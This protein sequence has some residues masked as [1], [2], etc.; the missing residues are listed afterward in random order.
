MSDPRKDALDQAPVRLHALV[1]G[2]VQGVNFRTTTLREAARRNLTGW[3]R[4]CWDGS[5]ETVA[6]GR[7]E[8]LEDFEKFLHRG[9]AAAEVDRV[10]V[11]YGEATGEFSG[12]HIRY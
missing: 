2:Y 10:D 5:V 8:L 3:V 6:E 12:F 9:P 1:H 7:R 11:T 4:N